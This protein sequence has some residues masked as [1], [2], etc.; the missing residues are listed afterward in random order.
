M[1]AS[2]TDHNLV[3]GQGIAS[4][5]RD[6]ISAA[7][8][9]AIACRPGFEQHEKLFEAWY[10]ERQQQLEKSLIA[11][12]NNGNLCTDSSIVKTTLR[13]WYLWFY[14]LVPSWRHQLELGPRQ[15]GL[16]RYKWE[17]GFPF[18][19]IRNG[20]RTFPQVFC[21]PYYSSPK[22]PLF[23]DDIIFRKNKTALFQL[24]VL[25]DSPDEMGAAK[26]DLAHLKE[27][28]EGELKVDEATYLV[29]DHVL[30]NTEEGP[31]DFDLK[32]AFQIIESG[33]S[34][35]DIWAGLPSPQGYDGSK[36]AKEVEGRYIIVRPDRELLEASD[37]LDAMI[38][39]PE[40]N[41]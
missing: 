21:S 11:T 15:K 35:P 10:G 13:D 16:I 41:F 22:Q 8:R 27:M 29:Q 20:G 30:L 36:L 33:T 4:G 26:A 37:A 18:L 39:R 28:G 6:A 9:L 5:F 24:V 40:I 31:V 17:T 3:G 34:D 2:R 19:A 7:W 1:N 38:S 12:I 23:T 14:Q 32:Y 25:I